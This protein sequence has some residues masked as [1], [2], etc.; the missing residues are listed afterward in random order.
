MHEKHGRNAMMETK[1]TGE[2]MHTHLEPTETWVHEVLEPDQLSTAKQRFGRR[3]L[4][5]RTLVL[6]WA[7]RIYV[8]LMVFLIAFQAW[9]AL[10]AGG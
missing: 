4:N 1:E 3:T 5:R 9:N 8:L 10:H 7:L 2:H 6:L